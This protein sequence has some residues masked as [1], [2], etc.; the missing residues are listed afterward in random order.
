MKKSR[1]RLFKVTSMSISLMGVLMIVATLLIF[2]YIGIDALSSTIS[3]TVDSGSAYDELV[4]LNNELSTLNVEY[5][6]VKA[7]VFRTG[8]RELQREYLDAE[9]ELVKA[10][11]ALTDVESALSAN[12]PASEVQERIDAAYGQISTARQ[13]LDSIKAKL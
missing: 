6:T 7:D 4:I 12:L 9:L 8:N 10:K 3:S 1:L 13:S 11:S 2:A 5:E